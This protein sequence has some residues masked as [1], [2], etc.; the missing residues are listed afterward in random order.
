MGQ[1]IVGQKDPVGY[2]LLGLFWV[3]LT[4]AGL[5]GLLLLLTWPRK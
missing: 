1:R 2:W 5:V 3:L 4:G